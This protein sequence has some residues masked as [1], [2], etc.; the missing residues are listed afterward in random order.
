M[1]DKV[2]GPRYTAT[3]TN[4][5]KLATASLTMASNVKWA[6]GPKSVSH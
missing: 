1:A 6:Q 3:P 5:A 4:T 2:E